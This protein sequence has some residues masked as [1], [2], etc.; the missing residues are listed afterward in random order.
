LSRPHLWHTTALSLSKIVLTLR[1][2]LSSPETH[3][4]VSSVSLLCALSSLLAGAVERDENLNKVIREL[5]T[6]CVETSTTLATSKKKKKKKE[7][8]TTTT[9]TPHTLFAVPHTLPYCDVHA[10]RFSALARWLHSRTPETTS[11]VIT[12]LRQS[13]RGAPLSVHTWLVPLSTFIARSLSLSLSLSLLT[14]HRFSLKYS[15]FCF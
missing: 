13:L 4:F 7:K 10:R 2:L 11:T 3:F 8:T 12:L 15:S 5:D 14:L 9:T 6:L 1:Q